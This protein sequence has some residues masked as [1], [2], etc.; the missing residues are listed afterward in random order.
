MIKDEKMDTIQNENE[1]YHYGVLGMRWGQRRA[2]KRDYKKNIN[3]AYAKYDK[4]MIK[5][6]GDAN[7]AKTATKTLKLEKAQ[8]KATY[9]AA[10]P[11]MS[12]K[13]KVA[14]GAT[15]VGGALAI[16]GGMKLHKLNTQNKMVSALNE[17]FGNAKLNRSERAK[18]RKS[19]IESL[20]TV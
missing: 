8:A 15:A 5:A 1:L 10:K 3:K 19:L 7:K 6:D 17:S 11:K 13:A 4:A 9:K 20:R 2:A 12:T 18:M 14:I 16:I